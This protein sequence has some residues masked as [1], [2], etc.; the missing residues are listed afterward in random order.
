[1]A[2]GQTQAP[3]APRI[4]RVRDDEHELAQSR[5]GR[6]GE[7]QVLDDDNSVPDVEHLGYDEGLLRV[8]R[9]VGA[10]RPRVTS[11]ECDSLLGEPAAEVDTWARLPAGVPLVVDAPQ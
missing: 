1:M 9:R 7:P 8:F 5:G 4:F 10:V 3:V 6:G 11:G 2:S